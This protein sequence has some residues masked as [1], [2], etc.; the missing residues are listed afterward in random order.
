MS[1]NRC[2]FALLV[3]RYG[4]QPA[5]MR[6]SH[7]LKRTF[8][9]LERSILRLERSILVLERSILDL[10]GNFLVLERCIN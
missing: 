9:R 2:F 3:C 10:E 4:Y 6:G 7:I 8:L 5:A 1:G